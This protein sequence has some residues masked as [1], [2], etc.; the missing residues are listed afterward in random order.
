ML[1][2]IIL[3][4]LALTLMFVAKMAASYPDITPGRLGSGSK[5]EPA[6]FVLCSKDILLGSH[7]KTVYFSQARTLSYSYA[8]NGK[9][10]WGNKSVPVGSTGTLHTLQIL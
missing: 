6:A 4:L 3:N 1:H 9:R 2:P 8:P 10:D 5:G 7:Q